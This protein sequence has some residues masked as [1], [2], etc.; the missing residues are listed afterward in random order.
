MR[1]AANKWIQLEMHQSIAQY[2]EPQKYYRVNSVVSPRVLNSH[3]P[4]NYF[5]VLLLFILTYETKTKIK[6]KSPGFLF[7]LFVYKNNLYLFIT[8]T[9]GCKLNGPH[10]LKLNHTLQNHS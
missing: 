9:E 7:Y 8:Y 5:S 6:I 10:S 4:V 1:Y 2:T 3:N